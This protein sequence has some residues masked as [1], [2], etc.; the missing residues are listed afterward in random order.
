MKVCPY[1]CH[2]GA[3]GNGCVALLIFT[4][5]ASRSGSII[6]QNEAPFILELD[7]EWDVE[8]VLIFGEVI[9]SIIPRC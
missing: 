4:R 3:W 2:K 5:Q 8:T 6:L 7:V 9:R 1:A